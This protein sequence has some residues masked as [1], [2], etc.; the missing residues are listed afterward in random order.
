MKLKAVIPDN[1][2]EALVRA[3]N[4]VRLSVME[5]VIGPHLHRPDFGSAEFYV[6]KCDEVS[7]E[8]HAP[9]CEVRLTGVSL[10]TDRCHD[11]F[12][13]A[14]TEIERIYAEILAA[15]L[16]PRT[17]VQLMVSIMLDQPLGALINNGGSTLVE[18]EVPA[19]TVPGKKI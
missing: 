1:F 18:G 4:N 2:P 19:I 9:M 14:R 7:G 12:Y 10:T 8:T 11:D 16:S 6:Q 3:L 17:E 5:R 13:N 15:H